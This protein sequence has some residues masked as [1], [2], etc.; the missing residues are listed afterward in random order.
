[1]GDLNLDNFKTGDHMK[2]NQIEQSYE[3]T[4]HIKHPTRISL[5][6]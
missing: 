3:I 1:M 4:Q 6:R 5:Q 2:I